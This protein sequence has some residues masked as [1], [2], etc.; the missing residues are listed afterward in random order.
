MLSSNG[1]AIP[2]DSAI[3]VTIAFLGVAPAADV[4]EIFWVNVVFKGIVT[5]ASVPLIYLVRPP[6]VVEPEPA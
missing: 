3:F 4:W 1:V 5:V 6:R 2:I